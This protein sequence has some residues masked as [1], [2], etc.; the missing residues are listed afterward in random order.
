MTFQEYTSAAEMHAAH[1][2]RHKRLW[3]APK[4]VMMAQVIKPRKSV[5]VVP[6]P[7][8]PVLRFM[9]INVRVAGW[10]A[11]DGSIINGN[12]SKQTP[13]API[14]CDRIINLVCQFYSVGKKDLVSKLRTRHFSQPRHV[15][16]HL[17]RTFTGRSLP[18][19]GR[20]LGGRD[21]TTVMHGLAKVSGRRAAD[22]DFDAEVRTLE[23]QLKSATP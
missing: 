11:W 17:M 13:F 23:E 7:S 6:K 21:H 5:A 12:I 2:E 8:G 18:E 3:A 16:M 14:T 1:R 10:S 20:I 22:P 9:S 4:P 15:A 19:I